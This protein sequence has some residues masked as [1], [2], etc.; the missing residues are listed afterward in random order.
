MTYLLEY[1][2]TDKLLQKFPNDIIRLKEPEALIFSGFKGFEKIGKV[3]FDFKDHCSWF[4]STISKH[5]KD[6][7]PDAYFDE[8]LKDE[9]TFK[10]IAKEIIEK[11]G[12]KYLGKT[13][14]RLFKAFFRDVYQDLGYDYQKRISE[15]YNFYI[16]YLDKGYYERFV[17]K[18][19]SIELI[20][21]IE[22]EYKF[23]FSDE[24]VFDIIKNQTRWRNHDRDIEIYLKAKNGMLY[25]TIAED[26]SELN[27]DPSIFRIVDKVQGKYNYYKGKL[28]ELDFK[29]YLDTLGFEHVELDGNSGSAD[30]VI[31]DEKNNILYVFSL[32]C[33]RIEN[34]VRTFQPKELRPELKLAY[35]CNSFQNY[36]QVYCILSAFDTEN[37][38]LGLENLDYNN[39]IPVTIHF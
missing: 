5:M 21:K 35:E 29:K 39:P 27:S 2:E 32:K 24:K 18:K 23:N 34:G 10:N 14:F 13:G 20:N 31:H 28:F 19:G 22:T 3:N 17:K 15:I 36:N 6:A 8:Y 12:K 9:K 37:S 7:N 1:Q 38:K 4:N 25:R 11:K 16:Y 33:E 26:Y 30:I